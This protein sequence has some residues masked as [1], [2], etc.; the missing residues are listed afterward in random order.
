[1][2]DKFER[3]VNKILNIALCVFGGALCVSAG[4]ELY[5]SNEYF[6]GS[7]FFMT[8]IVFIMRIIKEMLLEHEH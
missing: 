2:F 4:I 6:R 7:I 3:V 8:V 5:I 1:M